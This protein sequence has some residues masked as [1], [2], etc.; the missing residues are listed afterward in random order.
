M[1]QPPAYTPGVCNIGHGEVT[2]RYLVGWMGLFAVIALGVFFALEK[3]AAPYRL[4]LG[5]P[6]FVSALGFLQAKQ[7]FCVNYGMIGRFNMGAGSSG[8]VQEADA[9]KKDRRLSFKI[10]S[11]SILLGLAG[12]AVGYF[13]PLE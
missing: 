8:A 10:I 9:R 4:M 1:N 13:L 12:A 5:I 6:A 7:K 2:F 11:L 3:V